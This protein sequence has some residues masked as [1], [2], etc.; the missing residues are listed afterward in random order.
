VNSGSIS[1]SAAGVVAASAA[2]ARCARHARAGIADR[3]LR[4]QREQRHS[5][6]TDGPEPAEVV[7]LATKAVEVAGL[8]FSIQLT[9]TLGRHGSLKHKEARP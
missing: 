1:S 3:R 5:W 4:R 6:L 2:S 9:A 7:G 8:V